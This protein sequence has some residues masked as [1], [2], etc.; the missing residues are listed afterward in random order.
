MP[1]CE[2][3]STRL[4]PPPCRLGVDIE[5]GIAI[6][7][8]LDGRKNPLRPYP[9]RAMARRRLRSPELI[10]D[11][12]LGTAP[13]SPTTR[14]WDASRLSSWP[15][16]NH[17]PYR[18]VQ[19]AHDIAGINGVSHETVATNGH[20]SRSASRRMEHSAANGPSPANSSGI[21]GTANCGRALPLIARASTCGRM[22]FATLCSKEMPSS[23]ADSLVVSI[24]PRCAAGEDDAQN[25]SGCRVAAAQ[26]ASD[27][28]IISLKHV[29]AGDCEF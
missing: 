14:K 5:E 27:Q 19:L 11:F 29:P 2:L 17:G 8:S 16:H 24:A 13:L 3:R 10:A 18:R 20:P 4:A 26:R 6:G 22:R 12:D 15:A 23:S 7:T 1:A 21:L 28:V 25:G 9:S